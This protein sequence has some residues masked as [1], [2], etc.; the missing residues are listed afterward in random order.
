MARQ[1]PPDLERSGES[2]YRLDLTTAPV[3]E[4]QRLLTSVRPSVVINC[5][6]AT[7]GSNSELRAAN[8]HVVRK[9]LTA[10][11]SH[12][13]V[14]LVQFGSAAEY[15]LQPPHAAVPETADPQPVTPYGM[16]K[17]AATRAVMSAMAEK[18]VDAAVLRRV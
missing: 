17:L 6:G 16:T 12:P 14:R 2:W 13:T 15:G 18:R 10:L 7:V 3:S 11:S 1:P 8:F 4:H 9:L 5:A